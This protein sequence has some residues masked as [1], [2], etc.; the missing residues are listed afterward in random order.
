MKALKD[1]KYEMGLDIYRQP[2]AAVYSVNS[3][4]AVKVY[5]QGEGLLEYN[6]LPTYK[7]TNYVQ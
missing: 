2:L 7:T 5:H 3:A 1:P 4:K 6:V